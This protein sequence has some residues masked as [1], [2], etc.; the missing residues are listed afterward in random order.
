MRIGRSAT[1]SIVIN[2]VCREQTVTLLQQQ[3]SASQ[4]RSDVVPVQGDFVA[5]RDEKG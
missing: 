1:T 5:A 4:S 3:Q 2:Q